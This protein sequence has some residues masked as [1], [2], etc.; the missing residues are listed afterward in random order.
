MPGI[1]ERIADP[2]WKSWLSLAPQV[3]IGTEFSDDAHRQLTRW[4]RNR[5]DT[6][7]LSRAEAELLATHFLTWQWRLNWAQDD[8]VNQTDVAIG[9]T[10]LSTIAAAVGGPIVGVAAGIFSLSAL[11]YV[12][13]QE[14]D[15]KR[16]KDMMKD[17][18]NLVLDLVVRLSS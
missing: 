12:R 9:G 6:R 13:K 17:V 16:R 8:S 18:E 15:H 7:H 4:F 3:P 1:E 2:A 14:A 10:L 5:P 11:V